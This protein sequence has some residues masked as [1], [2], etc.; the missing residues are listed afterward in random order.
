MGT[1]G[2]HAGVLLA[3]GRSRRMGST[4]Q[5]LPVPTPAGTMPMVCASF[6]LL[7]AHAGAGMVVVSGHDAPLVRAALAPRRFVEVASDPDA[8]M[9]VSVKVGLAA[10]LS[11]LH[12]RSAVWLHLADVPLARPTTLDRLHAA[13]E[14][15]AGTVAALP[16]HDGHGGHPALI[17][18]CVA[19][20]I[21]MWTGDGGLRAFWREHADL[22]VRVP[23][24]DP[25]V[26]RDLDTPEAYRDALGGT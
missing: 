18:Y 5:L 6:D 16:E 9:L 25:G 21:L 4:K 24:D 22:R 8:D 26:V 7:A 12:C 11:G 14:A 2:G 10:A 1:A 23:V 19:R 17:P 15:Q 13:Y 3:A 20:L